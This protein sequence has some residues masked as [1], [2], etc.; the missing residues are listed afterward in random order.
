MTDDIRA[1]IR[2]ELVKH[3]DPETAAAGQHFF[4]EKVALYGVKT[5]VVAKIS[6]SYFKSLKGRDK[7]EIFALCEQLFQSGYNEEAWIACEWAYSQ[8]N[9]YQPY[10]FY[11]FE[12]WMKV[13]IDNWAKCDT[14]CN[15]TIGEFIEQHPHFIEKLKDW[16]KL[17]NRWLRRGASVSLIVPARR[18]KFL[19]DIFEI[20]DRL[21]LDD[22]DLVLKGYG[23]MLKAASQAHPLEVFEYV[24]R[25][26]KQMP[27]TALRYAIE[28]MQPDLKTEAI[29]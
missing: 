11:T 10:D 13:Y 18:G 6:K 1:S 25:K 19:P 22:E 14:L 27:R 16:T 4:K 26:K 12:R 29:K 5:P 21:L 17:Q 28:K 7:Q 20:A 23:W 3:S 15:H 9:L 24:M 8:R 2:A